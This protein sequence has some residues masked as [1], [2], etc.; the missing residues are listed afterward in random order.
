MGLKGT[1]L[2]GGAIGKI[3]DGDIIRLDAEVG[4]LELLVP[5]AELVLRPVADADLSANE[6]GFGRELFA[7]FRHLVSHPDQGASAFSAAA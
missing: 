5:A 3:N 4:M 2:E 7:G 6:F 1:T